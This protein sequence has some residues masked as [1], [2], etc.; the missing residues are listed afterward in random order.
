MGP[1]NVSEGSVRGSYKRQVPT[2]FIAA[3]TWQTVRNVTCL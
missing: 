1:Q 3:A 2:Y